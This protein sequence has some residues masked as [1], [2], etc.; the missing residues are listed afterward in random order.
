MPRIN[1]PATT[2]TE[3]TPTAGPARLTVQRTT[4]RPVWLV[5]AAAKP[6]DSVAEPDPVADALQLA[7]DFPAL[8]TDA[9]GGGSLKVF[10]RPVGDAATLLVTTVV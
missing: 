8:Q 6:A 2:W 3:L 5:F 4:A 7:D 10:A 9:L 1:C